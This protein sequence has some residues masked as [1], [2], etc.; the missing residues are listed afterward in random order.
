MMTKT[1][2]TPKTYFFQIFNFAPILTGK[3]FYYGLGYADHEKR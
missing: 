2:K 3:V 1:L